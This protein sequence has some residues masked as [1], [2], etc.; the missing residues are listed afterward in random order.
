MNMMYHEIRTEAN[1]A[2]VGGYMF[3]CLGVM[4]YLMFALTERV[5]GFNSLY[6]LVFT[7]TAIFEFS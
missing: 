2:F 1:R 4:L 5:K 6:D 7:S 3:I